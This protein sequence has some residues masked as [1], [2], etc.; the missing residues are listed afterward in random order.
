MG[1]LTIKLLSYS[2]SQSFKTTLPEMSSTSILRS[3]LIAI[4]SFLFSVSSQAGIENVP[5]AK[6]LE[7]ANRNDGIILDVRTP[8]EVAQ[9]HISG[10]SVLNIYDKDFERKLNLM[11]K[12]KPIYVYCRSGGRSSKAAQTMNANGFKSIYNLTGGIGAWNNAKLPL[13]KTDNVP[14]EKAAPL[15]R[16]DFEEKLAAKSVALADFHTEWCMPC[17]QM[18]PIIDNLEKEFANQASIIRVDLDSSPEL[19]SSFEVQGV[20]VFILFV[21]GK[22]QWRHSGTIDVHVLQAKIASAL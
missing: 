8:E 4:A 20:P 9:G 11:Q 22:E 6:F 12:D 21:D 10:A 15:S 18:A 17:K 3:T 16:N 7:L 14:A 13:E 5:P 2:I 19:G 1:T